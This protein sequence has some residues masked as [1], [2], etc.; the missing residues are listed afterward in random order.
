MFFF[1]FFGFEFLLLQRIPQFSLRTTKN[2][3]S[4]YA[5]PSMI[6]LKDPCPSGTVPI[7]RTTKENLITIR[8][9]SNN[10][11]PQ[12]ATNPDVHVSSLLYILEC[13]IATLGIIKNY[14]CIILKKYRPIIRFVK[15]LFQTCSSTK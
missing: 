10:I 11:H 9:L 7:R 1:F 5:R 2:I 13:R 12:S 3:S 15:M 4:S 8:S 6:G 14:T